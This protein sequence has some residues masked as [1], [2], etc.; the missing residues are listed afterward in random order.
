MV[1][2][3]DAKNTLHGIS[4]QEGRFK[5]MWRKRI[6]NNR[7][8]KHIKRREGMENLTLSW[9]TEGKRDR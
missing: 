9:Y 6:L 7:K 5:E 4:E 2:Q 3:M 8:R 1:L